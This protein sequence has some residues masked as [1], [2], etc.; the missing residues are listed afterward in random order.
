MNPPV[1]ALS[2]AY[3]L[4]MLSTVLWIGGLTTLVLIVLPAAERT[5]DAK[6]YAA[7]L[8]SLQRRLDPLGWFCLAVLAATG[9]FQM[10][11]SP[12][13]KG[14]LAISNPWA[15][16]ILMKHLLFGIMILV[17]VYLTWGVLPTLRRMALRQSQGVEA[18]H[19]LRFQQQNLWLLR[20]NLFLAFLIL[21]LTAFARV[22]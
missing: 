18:P 20:L 15:V 17:G 9:M 19:I 12:Q 22:S 21:A 11:A 2:I 8:E 13:Y 5:L 7:L 6:D 10:S 4:H 14:F 1:W 3:G 16:A